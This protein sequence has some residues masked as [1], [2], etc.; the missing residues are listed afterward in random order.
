M[1]T[2]KNIHKLT[3]RELLQNC[4]S[5]T[6]LTSRKRMPVILLMENVR[7]KY[8]V[9]AMFRTADAA[10]IKEVILTGLTP[11]PPD[12][13]IDKTALGATDVVPWRYCSNALSA[14]K[15]LKSQGCI[16]VALERTRESTSYFEFMYSFPLCLVVGSEVDG[17]S[18]GVLSHC[19]EAIDI[20]MLGRALSLNVATAC[21]IA[22]FEISK[23]YFHA[24]N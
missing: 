6:Q 8:N 3:H 19:D 12:T 24:R 4:P 7:S 20:P 13:H 2:S 17:V 9:G 15:E 23:R 5:Q 22:V 10:L 21:G 16:I 18:D 1:S 11:V 14:V